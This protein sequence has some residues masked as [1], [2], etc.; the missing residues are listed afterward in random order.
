MSATLTP[1]ARYRL[2]FEGTVLPNGGF[3]PDGGGHYLSRMH[4]GAATIVERL[5]DPAPIWWPGDVVL[6]KYHPLGDS[7]T[8][9][10]GVR[11][12]PGER[13]AKT[14]EQLTALWREGKVKPLLQ[15]GGKPF[16]M[17]RL[18]SVGVRSTRSAFDET[19]A[20]IREVGA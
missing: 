14:D 16:D 4:T 8:Y 3:R 7:Y 20:K 17:T 1:G 19:L 18:P 11:G 12:W 13:V 10:R 2:T 9:V 6:V 15:E 5:A